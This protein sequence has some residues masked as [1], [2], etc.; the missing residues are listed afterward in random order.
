MD[1]L[2]PEAFSMMDLGETVVRE[3][4]LGGGGG[5]T[6]GLLVNEGYQRGY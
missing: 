6:G 5:W 2:E 3:K 4:T 1:G